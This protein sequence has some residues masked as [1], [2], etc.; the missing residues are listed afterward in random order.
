MHIKIS[1][2]NVTGLAYAPVYNSRPA[3]YFVRE[4]KVEYKG[5]LI[6]KAQL[7]F[8]ISQP[9]GFRFFFMPEKEGQMTM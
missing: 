5:M 4:F 3:A 6:V 2:P 1:H 7:T 9:P 8:A